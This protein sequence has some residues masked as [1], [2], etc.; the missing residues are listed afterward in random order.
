VAAGAHRASNRADDIA[1]V[2]R[3]GPAPALQRPRRLDRLSVRYGFDKTWTY[4]KWK[5]SALLNPPSPG[6]AD[7]AFG[8]AIEARLS[9]PRDDSAPSNNMVGTAEFLQS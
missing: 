1:A 6:I 5:G 8:G 7:R 3:R 2:V 4:R 9:Q